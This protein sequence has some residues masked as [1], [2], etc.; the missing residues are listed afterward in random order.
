MSIMYIFAATNDR[1]CPLRAVGLGAGLGWADAIVD[2]GAI[3][4]I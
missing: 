1:R 2:G 4:A 3:A